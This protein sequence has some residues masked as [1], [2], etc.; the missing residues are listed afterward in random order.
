MRDRGRESPRRIL[1][2]DR[3]DLLAAEAEPPPER[4]RHPRPET[5]TGTHQLQAPPPPDPTIFDQ[6]QPLSESERFGL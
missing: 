3:V 4:D 5:P 2:R 6:L 1:P